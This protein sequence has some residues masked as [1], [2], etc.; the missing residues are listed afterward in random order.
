MARRMSLG[1]DIPRVSNAPLQATIG[2]PA[3]HYAPG[4]RSVGVRQRRGVFAYGERLRVVGHAQ[5]ADTSR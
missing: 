3:P 4:Q 5:A 1:F 2:V